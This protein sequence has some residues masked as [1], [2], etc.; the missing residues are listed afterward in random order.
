VLSCFI[1]LCSAVLAQINQSSG[2]TFDPFVLTPE[3]LDE[4]ELEAEPL[5]PVT[6][7]LGILPIF[8]PQPLSVLTT[9]GVMAAVNGTRMKMNDL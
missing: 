6:P 9:F 7:F 3:A 1:L 4:R 2:L 5:P 8:H